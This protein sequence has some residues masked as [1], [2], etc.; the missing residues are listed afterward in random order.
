MNRVTSAIARMK[1][2]I[3]ERINLG[4]TTAAKVKS[5]HKTLDMDVSEHARFQELKTLAVAEGKLTLEEGQSLYLLLGNSV[6]VFNKQPVEVKCVLTKIFEELL[7]R[8]QSA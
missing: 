8:R 2:Q 1:D 3:A 7:A 6:S 5:L 4:L